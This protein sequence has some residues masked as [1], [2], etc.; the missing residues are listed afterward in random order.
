MGVRLVDFILRSRRL[1]V[2]LATQPT[3]LGGGRSGD[4]LRRGYG[5]SSGDALAVEPLTEPDLRHGPH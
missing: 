3:P 5:E 2:R 4:V 1:L